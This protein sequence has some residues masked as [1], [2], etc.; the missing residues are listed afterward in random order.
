MRPTAMRVLVAAVLLLCV[1]GRTALALFADQAGLNDWTKQHVGEV[2]Q[3]VA[4]GERILVITRQGVLA[5]LL[6]NN[7]EIEWRRSYPKAEATIEK[8]LVRN[9]VVVTKGPRVVKAWSLDGQMLWDQASEKKVLDA[10]LV[11]D[12]TLAIL[13]GDKLLAFNLVTGTSLSK[14]SRDVSSISSADMRLLVVGKAPRV[15]YAEKADAGFRILVTDKEGTPVSFAAARDSF[16]VTDSGCVGYFKDASSVEIQCLNSQKVFQVAVQAGSTTL[17]ARDES[18]IVRSNSGQTLVYALD[19]TSVPLH[20]V[21]PANHVVVADQTRL[22]EVGTDKV[23][24]ILSAKSAP[25]ES[26]LSNDVPAG[27]SA[28]NVAGD[29][30]LYLGADASLRL[31]QLDQGTARQVWLREEALADVVQVTSTT[32]P[33]T[34]DAKMGG[35]RLLGQLARLT[36]TVNSFANATIQMAQGISDAIIRVARGGE[37]ELKSI[38][39]TSEEERARFGF[40]RILLFSTRKNKVFAMHSETGE[41]LWKMTLDKG[42]VHPVMFA[43]QDGDLDPQVLFLEPSSGRAMVVSA[44]NGKVVRS[45][46]SITKGKA[47]LQ[48]LLTEAAEQ[49]RKRTLV[50]LGDDLEVHEFPVPSKHHS[51]QALFMHVLDKTKLE[52]TGYRLNPG[53]RKASVAWTLVFPSDSKFVQFATV[54]AHDPVSS[55]VRPLGDGSLLV[56]HISPHLVGLITSDPTHGLRVHLIDTVSGRLVNRNSHRDGAEPVH[57][58]RF[59]NWFVYSFWNTK[60]RRVEL[61]SMTLYEKTPIAK[62]QLNPWT[63]VPKILQANLSSFDAPEINVLQRSFLLPGQEITA[64]GVTSTLR[65]IS[66]KNLLVSLGGT[67][68]IL[69]LDQRFID[70]RRTSQ[71]PTPEEQQEGLFQY[72]PELPVVPTH[73]LSYYRGAGE[74]G[75]N[76]FYVA[77]SLLEST[78][79]VIAVGLDIFKGRASPSGA[80]DLLAEDFNYMLLVLLITTLAVCVYVLRKMERRKSLETAWA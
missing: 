58:V 15:V 79:T 8:V 35:N 41:M 71:A 18:L 42:F 54:P 46:Q 32:F 67:G 61:I 50:V 23:I 70:P 24:R 33:H 6:A 21:A 66:A 72:Q 12:E 1:C 5:S 44:T 52:F 40:N 43:I 47:A 19:G 26:R 22:V 78:C 31:L 28:W 77:P 11:D 4:A 48:A 2:V 68:Q 64:L 34:V 62:R 37:F 73:V 7:G 16:A 38:S 55:P 3:A 39:E 80:F 45:E 56:K 20:R 49:G 17:E 75:A 36:E 74:R 27:A 76:L 30:L 59:E 63:S 57:A 14:T 10:V 65:G 53:A 13:T 69:M 29:R 9:N 60:A 25:V 51:G